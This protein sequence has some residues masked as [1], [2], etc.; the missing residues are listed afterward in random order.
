[1]IYRGEFVDINNEYLYKVEFQTQSGTGNKTIT[2]AGEDPVILK[3]NSDKLFDFIKTQSATVK[4]VSDTYLYNL[5]NS[6]YNVSVTISRTST[7]GDPLWITI[8]YGYVTPNIYNQTYQYIDEIEI[9][10][11]SDIAMLKYRDY[12]TISSNKSIY[13]MFDIV[14]KCLNNTRY[15]AFQF[16]SPFLYGFSRD[17]VGQDALISNTIMDEIYL[18]EVNFFDDDEEQTPWKCYEV[19]EEIMKIMN[20]SLVENDGNIYMI[21]YQSGI[22]GSTNTREW[23]IYPMNGER[24]SGTQQGTQDNPNPNYKLIDKD[25]YFSDNNNVSLD[26]TYRNI[27]VKVN[28]Y[29]YDEVFN[30]I[31]NPDNWVLSSAYGTNH[32][33]PSDNRYVPSWDWK[34][35]DEVHHGYFLYFES[36]KMTPHS[37]DN[38]GGTLSPTEKQDYIPVLIDNIQAQRQGN[39]RVGCGLMKLATYKTEEYS[40]TNKLDWRPQIVLYTGVNTFN[41]KDYEYE[42]YDGDRRSVTKR[43][44]DH[45]NDYM[46]NNFGSW[47]NQNHWMPKNPLLEIKS[48]SQINISTDS[49]LIIDGKMCI[50]DLEWEGSVKEEWSGSDAFSKPTAYKLYDQTI[51]YPN[52]RNWIGFPILQ[53]QIRVGNKILCS[54]PEL[55]EGKQIGMKYKWLTEEEFTTT[56]LN[57]NWH[58]YIEVPVGSEKFSFFKFYEITNTCDWRLGLDDARGFAVPMPADANLSGNMT[59]YV[60]G[61]VPELY[62]LYVPDI[63]KLPTTKKEYVY[64]IQRN[65]NNIWNNG[66][67]TEK[68]NVQI[69]SSIFSG[70][71]L[72]YNGVMP[73]IILVKDL[74]FEI[75]EVTY[76]TYS[77]TVLKKADNKKTDHE[78]ENIISVGNVIDSEEIE[79]KINTQDLEKCRS[80]SSMMYKYNNEM[81][82]ITKMTIDGGANYRIQEDNIVQNYVNHYKS[83]KVIFDC[84]LKKITYNPL[85]SFGNNSVYGK[86]LMLS[87]QKKNLKM[88][89]SKLHLIEI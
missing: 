18:N 6:G 45:V 5:Y 62:Y 19:L 66:W 89:N 84:D 75:K 13:S 32:K 20:L 85:C 7:N 80:F 46:V 59:I 4:I 82:Y 12:T 51:D 23:T 48:E 77:D 11:I 10:C 44:Q 37:Y 64:N 81:Q 21:N 56:Y 29:T 87:S 55:S 61:P 73:S 52:N 15:E 86:P 17:A 2:L 28:T 25:S 74:E 57:E 30:E 24:V 40:V 14:K 1:M 3:Q 63:R 35:K 65:P 9:E 47:T 42:E 58:C 53:L 50:N 88:G 69:E 34:D 39:Y 31:M 79:C 83:P 16:N 70:I 78:Y 68:I 38:N 27:K 33:Y 36:D 8:F 43:L 41:I 72:S 49:Y 60:V 26:E 54:T 76:H 22:A 67:E 71:H